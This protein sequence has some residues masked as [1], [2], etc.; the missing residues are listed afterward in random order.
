MDTSTLHFHVTPFVDILLVL[1]AFFV[2]TWSTRQAESDL[3]ISLPEAKHGTPEKSIASQVIINIR[4]NGEIVVNQRTLTPDDLSNLLQ[5]LVEQNPRQLVVI[6]ADALVD[7]RNILSV[8]D[9]CRGARV[10][11]IAFSALS[12]E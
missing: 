2:L 3:E 11:N 7:Y 4:K 9:I 6:R 10:A 1:I 5:G 12:Q 8:L